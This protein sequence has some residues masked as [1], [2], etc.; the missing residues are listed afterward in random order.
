MKI[1]MK[2]TCLIGTDTSGKTTKNQ[3]KENGVND[4]LDSGKKMSVM[5]RKD[6]KFV[7]E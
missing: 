6:S 1:G 5:I 2:V 7:Q 3:K 4:A